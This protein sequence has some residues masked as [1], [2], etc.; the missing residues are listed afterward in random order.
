MT[1]D[2]IRD[3][4][5]ETEAAHHVFETVA[6]KGVRDESWATWY[7]SYMLNHGLRLKR[8]PKAKLILAKTL[9]SVT[10]NDWLGGATVAVG[11]LASTDC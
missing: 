4:I 8:M 2:K 11:A 5:K 6:L 1:P 10:G 9:A 7:A 3:L